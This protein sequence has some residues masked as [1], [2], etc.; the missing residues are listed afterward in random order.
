MARYAII[1][2]AI[3]AIILTAAGS[4]GA[5]PPIAEIVS[6][7]SPV[8]ADMLER[9]EFIIRG[10]DADNDLRLC[11]MKMDGVHIGWAHFNSPD[12]NATAT[13]TYAFGTPGTYTVSATPLDNAANEGPDVTWTVEVTNRRRS[14]ELTVLTYNT[15]LF[16]DSPLECIIRCGDLFGGIPWETYAHEDLTRKVSIASRLRSS[17][18]DIVA[19]QEVWAFSWREFFKY[20]LLDKYPY[21]YSLDS[22]CNCKDGLDEI[23]LALR[24][25]I[26]GHAPSHL[27]NPDDYARQNHTLGNGLVLLSK[28]PLSDIKFDRF[29]VFTQCPLN[30]AG[31]DEAWADKGV[32]TATA[33]IGG[34]VRIGISHALLGE[35]DD[36]SKWN[37][38]FPPTGITTYQLK[39]ES[40]IFALDNDNTGHIVRMEDY[41]RCWDEIHKKYNYGA[42]WKHIDT[43][44]CTWGS[45]YDIVASFELGGHPYLFAL[46]DSN[47]GRITRINDDPSTGWTHI[48]EGT[49]D[50]NYVAVTSF[51][52]G[53]D[54]YLFGVD[55][56]NLAHIRRINDDP[57]TGWSDTNDGSWLDGYAAITTFELNGHPYIFTHDG[58]QGRIFR[59]DD[60]PC[61]G[62]T[63]VYE[64]GPGSFNY[65]TITSFELD[66]HPY[67]FTRSDTNNTGHIFRINDDPYTGW[68]E[69]SD[70]YWWSECFAVKS[71]YMNGHPY[72]FA[73]WNCCDWYTDAPRCRWRPVEVTLKRINDNPNT[74]WEDLLQLED[75]K[76]IRDETVV[77]EDG[78]PAIMM[79]DFNVHTEKYGIMDQLFGK[80][81]A[82]D[83]Y[84]EIHG[85]GVGGD[86][87]DWYK[88]DLMQ[89]FHPE[90]S[91][92]RIDYV[93]VKQTGGGRRLVPTDAYVI[94]DWQWQ[95]GTYDIDLSDH[96]PLVVKF[97]MYQGGCTARMKGDLNCDRLINFTDLSILGSAWMS[98]PNDAAWDPA[99]D[100]SDPA[101]DLIDTKDADALT[102]VWLT[103]PPVHNV[104][105]GTWYTFI[106]AGINYAQNG[107]EIEVSPGIYNE[108]IDFKG[109]AITLR[110]TNP[111]D[112][113]VVAETVIDGG[114]YYHVVQCVNGE[115][116]NTVLAGFTITGG[117]AN[118]ISENPADPRFYDCGGG[119][120]NERSSPTVKNCVFT[121]NRAASFGGGMYSHVTNQTTGGS[122][123]II[124][125]IFRNNTADNGGGMCNDWY[126]NATM[127]NCIFTGNQAKW[128]GGM[129][130]HDSSSPTVTNCT[131]ANNKA[132]GMF[133]NVSSEPNVTNCIL[134]DNEPYQIYDNRDSSATVTYSNVQ[135]Y[136][137]GV[138]NVNADPLFVDATNGDLR[139]KDCS[140]CVDAGNSDAVPPDTTDLDG[141]GN[142]TEPIPFDQSANPRFVDDAGVVD[143]GAGSSPI[144]DMGSYERQ[145]D[146]SQCSQPVYVYNA[147]Q[148]MPYINI[149]AAI[150]EANDGDEIQVAPLTFYEAIDFTGNAIRLYSTDG[151]GV[152]TI[153]GTGNYHVVQCVSGE[154]ANTVLN[155]FTITGGNANGPSD[156]DKCGGGMY[157]N[158]SSPTV[159]N[160]NFSGNS[161][162]S[163]GGM[164]NNNSSPTIINCN[165]SG[166]TAGGNGG[167]MY[168]DNSSSPTV[169]NC[170]FAGNSANTNGGAMFDNGSSKPTVTNCIFWGNTPNQI[171][172]NDYP[173]SLAIVKYSDVQHCCW[174]GI[175]NVNVD[176][177]FVD[178]NN[179][180]LRLRDC[181]MCVDAGNSDAVPSDTTDLDGDGNTTEPIPFDQDGNPRFMDD[182]G[183]VDIGAGSSPIVDMGSYERQSDSSQCSHYVY[184]ASQDKA[185]T[186]IQAAIDGANNGDK[187]EVVPRTFCEAINFKGKAITLHSTN[188]NDPNVVAATIINGAG[189]YHVVQCVSGEG[190][191]TI[192]DGFTITGG[193]AN[194]PTGINKCG[195]GMYCEN[196]SP[197]VTNCIFRGNSAQN[198]GAGMFNNSASPTVTGCTFSGNS[199]GSR[200]GGMFNDNYSNPNVVNCVFTSNKSAYYAG[201]LNNAYSNPAVTD[202]IFTLNEAIN[203][204]GA[205]ANFESSPTVTGCTFSENSS[206]F[207][208]GGMYNDNS[209]NPTVVNC[210]FTWNNAAYYAA[211]VN[212]DNSNPVVTDCIFALNEAINDG[213]AMANFESSPTVTGCTF[214]DNTA[215]GHGGG[216]INSVGSRPTVT[217]C[218]FTGNEASEAGGMFN[219]NGSSPTVINCAFT[220]NSATISI[221]GG[222]YN[223]T[224]SSPT[225][226][227]CTFSGNSAATDGG[228]MDN[229]VSSDPTV[230]NCT[231]SNNSASGKGGGVDNYDSSPTLTNC[232]LWGNTAPTGSQINGGSP[233]VTYSDVQ[234]GTGQSW[235]DTSCIDADPYFVD[236]DANDFRLLSDSPC[237]DA[238]NNSAVPS[239]ITTDLDDNPRFVDDP[240][241][242][243]TGSGTPP[244]VDMGAYEYFIP[245]PPISSADNFEYLAIICAD[246]L[247]GTKPEL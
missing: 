218:N 237:I 164:Y 206:G 18:A 61:D 73:R 132:G 120:Y 109:K 214:S 158:G 46:N 78:P 194:G 90:H 130:N 48:Y 187:I 229:R 173:D 34:P 98:E 183:V 129:Y 217:D 149:Q 37:T 171:W 137:P 30:I 103:M 47:Q 182:A 152:T 146:S 101:D 168:N 74:G 201:M 233:T 70:G 211:M 213:G 29:P 160:C 50:S 134:W 176:P 230:T 97:E 227:N 165:F 139:L 181:S 179:G 42:G 193:D 41:G 196:S 231:F 60:D 216:M 155:G 22:S 144:V 35:D 203:D 1:I 44:T 56:S 209:S 105:Q 40:Y 208:G 126:V 102:Q 23:H 141:D 69:M 62:W 8:E 81:G 163:G 197:M 7:N 36:K 148:E 121:G 166:N 26:A 6:P 84:A 162:D 67:I 224:N 115:D 108:A 43:G 117:D 71:F 133:N 207:R 5:A 223:L 127:I 28:W 172:D 247:A 16:E 140:V 86:T 128:G 118:G 122:P 145:S 49:V 39:G 212:N 68:S 32:L 100:I 243:D 189:H 219:N 59:I 107:D 225:V 215:G 143:I 99:C 33:D 175:G 170:T 185:Y 93:Y 11:G 167:G 20:N 221:G 94:R 87:A 83:A 45:E 17:N 198:D 19:L 245:P 52:L 159:I 205:M 222:M 156:V 210:S 2:L 85:P 236:V 14:L 55:D 161:A 240:G 51:E 200:G 151:P 66:G 75:M 112:P 202:C 114:G 65:V 153:N 124:N 239:G 95:Y 180:D 177:L 64:G 169:T 31:C 106:Q 10:T 63:P 123:T 178:A 21:S 53:G 3:T 142:T 241:T 58:D 38:H 138:G 76:I 228:G 174:P 204:G 192:L 111:S 220:D 232:I 191:D 72:L 238:G 157:N 150:D 88:N 235:F 79:G 92:D 184:N 15:H 199:S 24:A 136:W 116:A 27:P 91:P 244:I 125:C 190:P 82:V 234:G 147:T 57:Y 54:P 242:V 131:F 246:W 13:W 226:T 186:N 104:T 135:G 25:C 110:S 77:D 113:C 9:L 96:Y 89:Y 80:A 188:P 119:M 4:A 154:N 195:G 12:S